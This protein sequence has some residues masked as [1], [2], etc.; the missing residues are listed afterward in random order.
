[1]LTLKY[2]YHLGLLP[3]FGGVWLDGLLIISPLSSPTAKSTC[4]KYLEMV[5]IDLL[6][7]LWMTLNPVSLVMANNMEEHG[8]LLFDTGV[9]AI[10]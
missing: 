7:V 2:G 3:I 6:N 5:S 1:M 4:L 10:L 9:D 8:H